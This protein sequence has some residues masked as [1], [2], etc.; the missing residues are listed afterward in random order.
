MRPFSMSS[1]LLAAM[2]YIRFSNIYT[3]LSLNDIFF[4]QP[5]LVISVLFYAPT[6]ILDESSRKI[7]PV[8]ILSQ[9]ISLLGFSPCI[10]RSY[11]F[12][13]WL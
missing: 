1:I 10:S 2:H 13:I 7:C 12:F 9:Q 5:T 6:L 3:V 8:Q 4:V 11:N